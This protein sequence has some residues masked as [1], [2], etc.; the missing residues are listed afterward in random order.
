VKLENINWDTMWREGIE[1][2]Q[3]KDDQVSTWDRSAPQW[4]RGM[5]NGDYSRN[6]LQHAKLRS[7]WTVLDVGCGTGA[8]ALPIAKK[9]KQVTAL[10][11]SKEMLKFLQENAAR[12][13]I[14]NITCVNSLMSE[15]VNKGQIGKYDV[16][17]ASR[18]IALVEHD[19]EKQLN[20][21]NNAAKK[22]VY[23]TQRAS[24]RTYDIEVYKV[25]GKPHRDGPSYFIVLAQLYK[26]GIC[27]N[28]EFLECKM[29][30][31]F[32]DLN[33]AVNSW[34]NRFAKIG[35]P[36]NAADE[37]TLRNHLAKVLRPRTDGLLEVSDFKPTWAL[38]SWR[39][40]VEV[41]RR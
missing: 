36:L 41:R 31:T 2:T 30:Y 16:V 17:I 28:L 13:G 25:L 20:Y 29:S 7:D 38:I 12:D 3:G 6:F 8:L 27:A 9:V 26:M 18:S 10:D 15:A 32:K 39:N 4:N 34:K 19:L 22:Y 11:S 24:E 33:D 23:I 14:S 21:I 35:Q 1:I 40:G 37:K 5:N